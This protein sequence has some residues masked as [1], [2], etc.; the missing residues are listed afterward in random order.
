MNKYLVTLKYDPGTPKSY[1]VEDVLDAREAR[2]VVRAI[3]GYDPGVA[4]EVTPL[5]IHLNKPVRYSN[6]GGNH[7]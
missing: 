6:L 3:L 4:V 5:P 2:A 7:D 1:L